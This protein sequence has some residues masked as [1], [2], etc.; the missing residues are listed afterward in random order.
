MIILIHCRLGFT[1]KGGPAGVGIAVGT[2]V[3]R[4]MVNVA[5][6]DLA[7]SMALWGATTTVTVRIA[8]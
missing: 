4:S 7:L 8:G 6:L 2:A 1:A 5:L 3:R